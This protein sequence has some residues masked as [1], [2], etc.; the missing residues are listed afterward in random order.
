MTGISFKAF[1]LTSTMIA[2]LKRASYT[3]QKT[4]F[5]GLFFSG[6]KWRFDSV[7]KTM[8][9]LMD[10]EK[11]QALQ[12]QSLV[13]LERWQQEQ[14]HAK[15]PQC[16]EVVHS[17]SSVAAY[18]ATK[19][20][21]RLYPVLNFAN[22]AVPGGD[23]FARGNA[24]EESLWTQSTCAL[25]LLQKGVFFDKE[26]GEFH[27]EKA[28]SKLIAGQTFM[29]S[30]ELDVLSKQLNMPIRGAR[31]VF[32]NPDLQVAFRG[33]E[34]LVDADP[35][36]PK[37]YADS[38]LSFEFLSKKHVFPFYEMRSSAP[39]IQHGEHEWNRDPKKYEAE[40]RRRIAAQLDTLVLHGF[41]HAILG[42]WGCGCFKNNPTIV[43]RVY[44]EEIEK[45]AD[46]FTHLV[47]PIFHK[48][49]NEA[50]NYG[51]FKEHLDGIVLNGTPL[52]IANDEVNNTPTP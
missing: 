19:A 35:P 42:A 3:H 16:V 51:V 8:N 34:V 17:D 18:Q 13:N 31:K 23:F 47:F 32:F 50:G 1:K 29:L 22:D 9:V 7:L 38:D 46:Y 43:A 52:S 5:Y 24:Q 27:Y 49:G 25:S 26:Q 21:G 15:S 44:R 39:L 4:G 6:T 30:K 2:Q 12:H 14:S 45:R 40:L 11:L 20:Y 48:V 36:D 33:P 10:A 41:T 28:M 37:L